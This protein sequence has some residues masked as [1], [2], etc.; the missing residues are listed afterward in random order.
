MEE[1]LYMWAEVHDHPSVL[2]TRNITLDLSEDLSKDLDAD[3]V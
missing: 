3:K 2:E 1:I